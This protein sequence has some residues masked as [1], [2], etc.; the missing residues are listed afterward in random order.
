MTVERILMGLIGVH[1][2]LGIA[3]FITNYF[4]GWTAAY[5]EAGI[6]ANTPIGEVLLVEGQ[7]TILELGPIE[8]L[9]QVPFQF[10]G[11]LSALAVPN[12]GVLQIMQNHGGF[13]SYMAS[14][15]TLGSTMAVWYAAWNFAILL[16]RSGIFGSAVGLTVLIGIGAA[17][18]LGIGQFLGL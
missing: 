3:T 9:R 15:V 16:L 14:F 1:I 2:A 18:A 5:G 7:G 6:I 13:I 12:Y 17:S 10:I 8:L 4:V 11:F